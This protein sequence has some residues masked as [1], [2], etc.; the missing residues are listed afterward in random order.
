MSRYSWLMGT[1]NELFAMSASATM[2]EIRGRSG[3]AGL[4]CTGC[5]ESVAWNPLINT[6][7]HIPRICPG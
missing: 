1:Q 6:D 3:D 2:A 4:C 5:T 7:T